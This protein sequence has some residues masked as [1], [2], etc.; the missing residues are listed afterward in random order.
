MILEKTFIYKL[1]EDTGSWGFIE[2]EKIGIFD[3][4][5]GLGVA[6]DTLEHVGGHP[7]PVVDELMAFGAIIAFRGHGNYWMMFPHQHA[8]PDPAYQIS[9]G[10]ENALRALET[11]DWSLTPIEDQKPLDEGYEDLIDR[12]LSE[13]VKQEEVIYIF[14]GDDEGD[15]EGNDLVR[16]VP[17]SEIE[18]MRNWMRRGCR[19]ALE[20]YDPDPSNYNAEDHFLEAFFQIETEVDEIIKH[21]ED[22]LDE[23]R[24][25]V[26]KIDTDGMDVTITLGKSPYEEDFD[27][28]EDFQEA[29]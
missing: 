21:L 28:G 1:W 25:L 18:F 15:D 19:L 16:E 20:K 27:E 9:G 5:T 6:H 22:G 23:D 14:C 2:R 4:A 8:I 10:F 11:G 3:P 26:V 13:A 24:E 12:V 7:N 17:K 29:A